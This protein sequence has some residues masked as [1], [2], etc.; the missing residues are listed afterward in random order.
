MF[1]F[2]QASHVQLQSPCASSKHGG[3]NHDEN[4]NSFRPPRSPACLALGNRNPF[5]PAA[6]RANRVGEEWLNNP[7]GPPT[8]KQNAGAACCSVAGAQC[9]DSRSR[10][11]RSSSS[12]STMTTTI[13]TIGA[14]CSFARN[15]FGPPTPKQP[16]SKAPP[17]A[18]IDE[19]DGF[20]ADGHCGTRFEVTLVPDRQFGLGLELHQSREA[21][22][23]DDGD[24]A[25]RA[26]NPRFAV[27]VDGVRAGLPAARAAVPLQF[28]DMLLSVNGFDVR[29]ARI[30]KVAQLMT[31]DSAAGPL[32]LAFLRPEG[33][34]QNADS[35]L[36]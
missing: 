16:N 2:K 20:G 32:C 22:D 5:S 25:A 30:D 23:D 12:S 21:D 1:R 17:A 8:P 36:L 33:K 11:R 26:Y 28:G 13:A 4:E 27:K 29:T 15:P 31:R 35:E 14:G 3:F 18:C 24:D 9:S 6:N 10:R 19:C 34:Q 7:F